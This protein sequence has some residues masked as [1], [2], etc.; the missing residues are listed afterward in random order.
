MAAL[1]IRQ[2]G[3]AVAALREERIVEFER[4]QVS[5][6]RKYSDSRARLPSTASYASFP[7]RD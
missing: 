2:F 4:Q 7:C 3:Q 1:G 6:V 5:G